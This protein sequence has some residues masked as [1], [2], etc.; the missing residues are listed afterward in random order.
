MTMRK[1]LVSTGFSD[2]DNKIKGLSGAD[3]MVLASRPSMGKTSLALN[4]VA[5][6]VLAKT[7]RPVLLFSL[8]MNRHQIMMRFIASEAEVG[9]QG[10]RTGSFQRNRWSDITGAA[11]RLSEAPLYIND[12][13]K[14][15]ASHPREVMHETMDQI[16][17]LCHSRGERGRLNAAK[18]GPCITVP[19]FRVISR[20]LMT[21]MRKKK[22]K[23]GVIVIDY[24]QLIR[25]ASSSLNRRQ[26]LSGISRSLKRLARDLSVPVI[27]LSQVGQSAEEKG[28]ADARPQVSDLHESGTLGEDADILAF[29]YRDEYYH[30]DK[31]SS[32]GR[33]E[34][35]VAKNPRGQTG[36]LKMKFNR[37]LG[38]FY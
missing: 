8:A 21:H 32:A 38:T 25:G 28:R 36:T 34:I 12:T 7:P 13:E 31:L 16:E 2:L 18:P 33:A 37:E 20:R 14:M 22:E 23:L 4:I 24:A 10:L 30:P 29:I 6:I 19:H 27:V 15:M 35:I 11:A 3:L 26:Q 9:I 1:S 17:I 5:N